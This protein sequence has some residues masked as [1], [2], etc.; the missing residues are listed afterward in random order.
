M[1]AHK[2]QCGRM[3][4]LFFACISKTGDA[5]AA[6][7]PVSK[8]HR[9]RWHKPG[10]D[11]RE[12]QG[13]AVDGRLLVFGGY[14]PSCVPAVVVNNWRAKPSDPPEKRTIGGCSRFNIMSNK[15]WSLE[16]PSMGPSGEPV[17]GG[18]SEMRPLPMGSQY[19]G[20]THMGNV[21]DPSTGAVYLVGG[22]ALR[23]GEY[24]RLGSESISDACTQWRP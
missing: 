6:L 8:W 5:S 23:R 20:N 22:L 18:W 16:L 19:Q 17:G 12:P 13:V 7:Y 15:T 2:S 10:P 14:V 21:A 9:L 4:T 24:G 1:A 3:A 11:V